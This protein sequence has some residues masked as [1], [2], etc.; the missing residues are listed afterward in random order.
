MWYFAYLFIGILSLI[1]P[2]K[3]TADSSL[4]NMEKVASDAY[5]Y[6]YPAVI[7][8][9]SKDVMTNTAKIEP[10]VPK[11]PINQLYDMREFPNP[12]FHD[13]VS[14]NADTLYT[15]GW[16]DLSK[17]PYV[18]SVPDMGDR[19]YLFPMLDVWTNVFFSPG[20]RTTGQG[21]HD[22]VITG[23]K[24]EGTLPTGLEEY[25]SPS[26]LVWIIGRIE[27]A[28]PSDYGIVHQLQ[29]Q[30]KLTPLSQWGKD[31]TPPVD[32][33]LTKD[34]SNAAPVEQ[35]FKMDGITFFKRLAHILKDTPIPPADTEFV[36]E[37]SAIG[38]IPGQ[39]FDDSKLTPE[40]KQV[41][42]QSVLKSQKIIVTEFQKEPLAKVANGWLII[43]NTVGKYGTHYLLRA[44]IAY[45]GLGANLPE[46][47]VYPMA[48]TDYK[49]EPL[50]G[51]Y[52]YIIHFEKDQLPPV[53]GFWSLTMYN[54]QQFFVENPINRYAIGNRNQ[55]KFNPDG[56]L[57]IYIQ[58][59][60][61][62]AEKESNWL[63][64]PK[65][66]FNV[67]MRLYAPQAPVLNGTW[68][69]PGIMKIN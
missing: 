52:K 63:P 1:S 32:V 45:G 46:D 64:A 25:R 17:E 51:T 34:I 19:Y 58:N 18:L 8:D 12:A 44:A 65:G 56:S 2:A 6:G 35:V 3:S 47:A 28:G 38:L 53:K 13:V 20:T 57:D 21:K 26:D 29:D 23:P 11:A 31:Y 27:S 43:N 49:G 14:P 59:E 16:L 41:I 4:I 67:M 55:L 48:R 5:I 69:P 22:F 66:L 33:P 36:K 24:W 50:D 15:S 37:F 39:E 61:P 30:F 10:A 40:Q 42:N 54:N 7:M 60:S 9:V 68:V 62:G